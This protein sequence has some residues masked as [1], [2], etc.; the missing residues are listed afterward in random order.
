MRR[1]Q[2]HLTVDE[3]LSRPLDRREIE[4]QLEADRAI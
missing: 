4:A 2:R 1:A 3:L